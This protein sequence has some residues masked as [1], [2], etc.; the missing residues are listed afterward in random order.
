MPSTSLSNVTSFAPSAVC[1]RVAE[2]SEV[3]ES[4]R[5]DTWLSSWW[6]M[7]HTAPFVLAILMAPLINFKSATFFTK[8]NSLGT[9]SLMYLLVMVVVKAISWGPHIDFN[10]TSSPHYTPLFQS[11]FPALSGTLALSFF[12]H[13][14]IISLMKNNRNQGHNVSISIK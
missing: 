4:S 11:S 14:I 8:F 7:Q 1:P 13:N 6:H 10:D 5:E 2:Q 3:E 9:I 12:I